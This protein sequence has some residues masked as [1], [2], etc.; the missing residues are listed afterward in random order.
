MQFEI[1]CQLL[2]SSSRTASV[3]NEN[4]SSTDLGCGF[5]MTISS[6]FAGERL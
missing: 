1:P 6:C 3:L 5:V 2:S 4:M